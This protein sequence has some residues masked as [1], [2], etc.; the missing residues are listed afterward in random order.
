M[1]SESNDDGAAGVAT[2]SSSEASVEISSDRYVKV[3]PFSVKIPTGA[4]A[5][6]TVSR[7]GDWSSPSAASRS[8]PFSP[9]EDRTVVGTVTI[10]GGSAM[11]WMGWGN[12]SGKG[13]PAMG[14]LAVAVPPR[15]R[16]R[17]RSSSSSNNN[18]ASPAFSQ[19][20]GGASEE[21]Q[22]TG[23]Q[24]ACRL[25][26]KTGTPVFVALSLAASSS[27]S[28]RPTSL[29]DGGDASDRN[30]LA[31]RAAALAEREVAT[32][33]ARELSGEEVAEK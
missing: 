7:D 5:E 29:G 2:A 16:R 22:M 11:V 9:I 21:D 24:A 32:I 23:C 6:T 1:E 3:I 8:A 20:V 10:M 31:Q 27:S 15:P 13:L 12:G 25:S 18:D 30:M 17:D 19:L 28:S 14:P 26:S 4:D 33:L